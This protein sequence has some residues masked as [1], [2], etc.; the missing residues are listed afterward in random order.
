MANG[1]V[2]PPAVRPQGP[3]QS[4]AG[5][6]GV[7]ARGHVPFLIV[8]LLVLVVGGYLFY[9]HE[10]NKSTAAA[11]TATTTG[12][13]LLTATESGD[14][15]TIASNSTAELQA[16]NQ[17]YGTTVSSTPVPPS[18]TVPVAPTTPTSPTSPNAPTSTTS[19]PNP[20]QVSSPVVATPPAAVTPVTTSQANNTAASSSLGYAVSQMGTGV[21][22]TAPNT[23]WGSNVPLPLAEIENLNAGITAVPAGG[24][25]VAGSYDP[26]TGIPYQ[27]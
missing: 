18:T 7:W 11:T 17:L 4:S 15:D 25:P 2:R 21:Q 10:K 16:L 5:G 20:T 12:T 8:G 22:F 13:D 6:F 9:K 1:E 14:L 27:T 19:P 23:G 26:A 3:A 24:Y